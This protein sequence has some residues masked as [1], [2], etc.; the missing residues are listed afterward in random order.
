MLGGIKKT[1]ICGKY[2]MRPSRRRR[3]YR[4]TRTSQCSASTSVRLTT[5]KVHAVLQRAPS[6]LRGTFL[7]HPRVLVAFPRFQENP[8]SCFQILHAVMFQILR[9]AYVLPRVLS[10]T[11]NQEAQ[12][13]LDDIQIFPEWPCSCDH[14]CCDSQFLAGWID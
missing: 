14:Q 10:T 7:Q 4:A 13:L 2:D 5:A 6:D 8:H 3:D 1:K 9:G 12:E 11:E